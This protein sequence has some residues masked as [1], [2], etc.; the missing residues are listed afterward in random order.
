MKQHFGGDSQGDDG[1]PSQNGGDDDLEIQMTQHD[2]SQQFIC[3]ITKVSSCEL[4]YLFAI[5]GILFNSQ[6]RFALD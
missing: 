4:Y 2:D 3:P 1:S 5:G 6:A